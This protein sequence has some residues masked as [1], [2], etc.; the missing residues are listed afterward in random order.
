VQ[1]INDDKG[2]HEQTNQADDAIH[3]SDCSALGSY[4]S[5]SLSVT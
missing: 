5:P 4:S 1:G 3:V 2:Q